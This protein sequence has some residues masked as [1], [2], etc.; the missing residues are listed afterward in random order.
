MLLYSVACT[1]RDQMN[2]TLDNADYQILVVGQGSGHVKLFD[3]SG[4]I[5]D[6]FTVGFNPHEIEISNERQVFV[7]DFGVED[8]DN[9]IGIPGNSISVFQLDSPYV[10]KWLTSVQDSTSN[11]APH[12]VKLRPPNQLELFVNVEYGDSMLV[13]NVSETRIVRSFSLAKG[14]HNFE[15]STTGDTLWVIAGD[16]GLYQYDANSG[17][18]LN[19]F[20]TTSPA[21]GLIYYHRDKSLI[22]SCQNEVCIVDAGS[23]S[24]RKHISNLNVGQIIY[25]CLMPDGKAILAPCPYDNLVLMLDLE[26][27]KVLHRF[28]TGKAPIYAQ[29]AP[30]QQRAYISNALD[31]HMTIIELSDLSLH[32][33][34]KIDKPNGLQ[35]VL[36]QTKFLED[37]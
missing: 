24:T 1:P 30:D 21:R 34:G 8:Y 2:S 25:S 17:E 31:D 19:H 14:S 12:G 9:T 28:R 32:D 10:E 23:L 18:E 7:S 4:T 3:T 6:S 11:L 33:F 37:Y 13:Y 27:G 15:F 35:F 5:L 16:N 22:L 26:D 36:R 20:R 29:I